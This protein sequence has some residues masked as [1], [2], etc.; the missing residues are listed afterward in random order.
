VP[1][2][3]LLARRT[4]WLV[5]L[6][7]QGTKAARYHGHQQQPADV[8]PAAGRPPSGTDGGAT[9]RSGSRNGLHVPAYTSLLPAPEADAGGVGVA[10]THG[11]VH[12]LEGPDMAVRLTAAAALTRAVEYSPAVKAALA[13]EGGA[14]ANA[15]VTRLLAIAS[16]AEG[17]V[18][19]TPNQ[20][21]AS[22]RG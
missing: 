7:A 2:S 13:G 12:W 8:A 22:C 3:A 18:W 5:G 19:R 21:S 14:V 15:A 10:C 20:P 11:L 9:G 17:P 1:T 16:A 6:V 4:A